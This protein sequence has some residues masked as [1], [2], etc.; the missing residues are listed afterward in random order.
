MATSKADRALFFRWCDETLGVEYPTDPHAIAILEANKCKR[1]TT[2]HDVIRNI[3]RIPF[4]W[5]SYGIGIK[6]GHATIADEFGVSVR[7][8][9]RWLSVATGLGFMAQTRFADS[10]TGVTAEYRVVNWWDRPAQQAARVT[11]L[12]PTPGPTP[13]Q[14]DPWGNPLGVVNGPKADPPPF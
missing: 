8:V 5:G 12:R 2:F 9:E 7:T 14:S 1:Q 3:V 10:R 11:Q 13:A 4:K 6:P